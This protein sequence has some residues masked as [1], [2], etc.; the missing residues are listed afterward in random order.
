MRVA[1]AQV[2]GDHGPALVALPRRPPPVL[3]SGTF[4][5]E[6]VLY[7]YTYIDVDMEVDVDI[8]IDVETEVDVDS[9][10]ACFEVRCSG[11]V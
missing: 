10:F 2:G 1:R 11:H 7:R 9:C 6:T 5:R 4:K 8:D 3:G